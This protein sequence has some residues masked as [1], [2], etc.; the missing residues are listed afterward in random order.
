MT[1]QLA[2]QI[3]GWHPSPL[4]GPVAKRRPAK[5]RRSNNWWPDMPG[6]QEELFP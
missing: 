4:F 2:L 1:H 5:V 6:Q 3:E